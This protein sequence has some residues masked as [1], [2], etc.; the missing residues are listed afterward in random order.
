MQSGAWRKDWQLLI[1]GW[2]DG[3]HLS[4]LKQQAGQL[5]L[6]WSDVGSAE[7]P[8]SDLCFI[9]PMFG[10]EKDMLMRSADAFIL[11][12]FSEGLPMSVLEAW[13]YGLPVL[14]TD[15]CNLPEGFDAGAALRIAPDEDSIAQGLADLAAMTDPERHDMGMKGRTLVERQYTWEHIAA[16]MKAVYEW[17]LGGEKP[18]CIEM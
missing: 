14:M 6:R 8:S 3:N 12:S 2:D 16:E 5:G 9:G 4:G 7:A 13:S 11:P 17:C 1:A 10:D 18:A 15:F